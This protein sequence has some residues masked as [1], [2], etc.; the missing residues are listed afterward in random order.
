[1][2][3]V[4]HFVKTIN[5]LLPSQPRHCIAPKRIPKRLAEKSEVVNATGINRLRRDVFANDLRAGVAAQQGINR[6]GGRI[7]I[8]GKTVG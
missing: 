1:M 4:K 8:I 5:P 7:R 3:F 2:R 6:C